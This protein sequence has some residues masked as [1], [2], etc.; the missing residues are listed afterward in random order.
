MPKFILA[1]ALAFVSFSL[2]DLL[3][4][5]RLPPK[6]EAE[7]RDLFQVS[8]TTP[9]HCFVRRHALYLAS[10]SLLTDAVFRVVGIG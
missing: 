4:L 7:R 1:I 9:G 10:R 2:K 8:A 6:R 3:S 5:Q